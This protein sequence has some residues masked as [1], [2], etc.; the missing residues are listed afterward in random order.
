[1]TVEQFFDVFDYVLA[2]ISGVIILG[3]GLSLMWDAIRRG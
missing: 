3:S 2:G 1:M